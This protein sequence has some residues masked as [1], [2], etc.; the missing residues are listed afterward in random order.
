MILQNLVNVEPTDWLDTSREE[1]PDH[2]PEEVLYG[3]TTTTTTIT[4][5]G[6]TSTPSLQPTPR[7]QP[8]RKCRS[9]P[10]QYITNEDDLDEMLGAC[11]LVNG[12][13]E[14]SWGS[15]TT[16][17]RNSDEQQHNA[18]ELNNEASRTYRRRRKQQFLQ[19]QEE[20]Q[21]LLQTNSELQARMV[22]LTKLKDMMKN[23]LTDSLR[24]WKS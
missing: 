13:S 20:E 23:S 12:G 7:R 15:Q 4:S 21:R 14:A 24:N 9:T 6:L 17:R 18:R 10:S 22:K 8:T 5:A 3:A 11:E 16:S 1:Q 2:Q 19:L